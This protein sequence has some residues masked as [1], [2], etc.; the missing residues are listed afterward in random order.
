VLRLLYIKDL[1]ALQTLIDR[2]LVEVQVR[3]PGRG[4]QVRATRRR[5]P[6]WPCPCGAPV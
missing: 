4:G 2:I 3:V 5:A 6:W 1:R